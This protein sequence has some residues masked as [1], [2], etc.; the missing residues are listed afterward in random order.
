MYVG[1]KCHLNAS[2][3]YSEARSRSY[4]HKSVKHCLFWGMTMSLKDPYA[5]NGIFFFF[6]LLLKGVSCGP[7]D[8]W[9]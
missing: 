2:L 1:K 3:D 4:L 6:L 8:L 7:R 9:E 5:V